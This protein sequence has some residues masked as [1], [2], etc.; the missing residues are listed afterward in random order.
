MKKMIK[1][2]VFAAVVG[3][4]SIVS[5][6]EFTGYWT[7]ID[8]ETKDQKS[9]VQITEKDG[10]YFGKVVH[11]FKDPNAVAK[12]PGSPKILGLQIIRDMKRGGKGLNDGK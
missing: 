1:M 10:V 12:L 11:L 2:A 7:T 6:K 9:V 8:D 3:L 4:A 5:A